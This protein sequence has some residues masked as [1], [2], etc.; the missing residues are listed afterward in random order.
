MREC[1][2]G[3][4]KV[5]ARRTYVRALLGAALLG[6]AACA[7]TAQPPADA[8][9]QETDGGA[10]RIRRIQQDTPEQQLLA[11]QDAYAAGRFGEVVQILDVTVERRPGMADAHRLL[12]HALA[13]LGQTEPARLA[14]AR[15]IENGQL[16]VDVLSRLVELDRAAGREADALNHLRL[17]TVV[18]PEEPGWR[19]LYGDALAAAG[20]RLEAE[21]EFTALLARDPGHAEAHL[22]LG[23]LH[24]EQGRQAEA[25]ASFEM[26]YQLGHPSPE[27][28]RAI[29][30]L[31]LALGD[32]RQALLWHE[33]AARSA[34]AEGAAS[35][36]GAADAEQLL[37]MSE[38]R[39]AL[40]DAEGAERDARAALAAPTPADRAR[41]EDLR[42][43]AALARG[44]Q[45][46]ALAHWRAAVDAGL[47]N[48]EVFAYLGAQLFNR[49]EYGLAARYLAETIALGRNDATVMRFHTLS[50]LHAG[51]RTGANAALRQ[52][53]EVHG[54]DDTA[55]ELMRDVEGRRS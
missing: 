18:A 44:D 52:Y 41:A 46:G 22:R 48:S 53:V 5:T 1:V 50:L 51:D 3:S 14:L 12:G 20:S 4:G 42:G 29:A 7:P 38:L 39:L 24:L 43:R 30:E 13:E 32:P 19:L 2:T 9:A 8:T 17:L 23:N 15:A 36:G 27:L 47:R 11:A 34:A 37:R 28:P 55:R 45:D 35:G 33:R 25:A 6:L 26:A 54:L 40:G 21:R 10:A 31:W 16:R 49:R